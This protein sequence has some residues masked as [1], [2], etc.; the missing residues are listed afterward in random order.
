MPLPDEK[1][2][3]AFPKLEG[4]YGWVEVDGQPLEVYGVDEKDGKAIAYIEAKEGKGFV[5]RAGDLRTRASQHILDVYIDGQRANGFAIRENDAKYTADATDDTSFRPFLFSKLATTDDD[6]N[7]CTDETYVKGL[8]TVRLQYLRVKNMRAVENRAVKGAADMKP[9]HEK[10]KKATLSHQASYGL[11]VVEPLKTRSTYEWVDPKDSPLTTIDFRYRSRAILQFQDYI[12]AS[13]EPE[14]SA[15][16]SPEPA[17]STSSSL[18][19]VA[20]ASQPRRSTSSAA[21]APSGSP[22]TPAAETD[23]IA[24]LEAEFE[25][26]RRQERMAQLQHELDDLRGGSGGGGASGSQQS[27]S[28]SGSQ[29]ERVKPEPGSG[30]SRS[31]GDLRRAP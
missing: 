4:M 6:E 10:S 5:V 23:R 14:A 21:P 18:Q 11:P 15:S 26:L 24:Q 30:S 13:P 28:P 31:A 9:I 3:L 16:P 8:G 17:A 29:L 7:A 1:H 12:P 19:P 27:Q 20:G 22:L 25:S 2:R